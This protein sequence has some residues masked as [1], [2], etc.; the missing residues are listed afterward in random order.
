MKTCADY[1][2]AAKAALG[3]PRMSDR[4]LGERLGKGYA[5]STINMASRG[6]M[7]DPMAMDVAAVIGC[8]PG[9]VLMVARLEREKDEAV[10]AALTAWAG[11][12]FGLLPE[13]R[14]LDAV[15]AGPMQNAPMVSHGGVSIGGEGGIR[16]HGTLRYA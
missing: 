14:A 12:T 6:R 5:N 15:A 11:K 3:N 10:K 8:H 7:T 13:V 2:A 4:E 1:I 9:E 16:T